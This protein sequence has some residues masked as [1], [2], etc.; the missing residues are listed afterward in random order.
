[1][2]E[3]HGESDQ[4]AGLRRLFGRPE[5][6]IVSFAA[7]GPGVGKS[8]LVANLA[9][10][11]ARAGKEVLV[12]DE[13]A[14]NSVAAYYGAHTRHDLQQ[15]VNREKT[16]AEVMLTVA[17]GIRV[18]PAARAVARLAKL[19]QRQQQAL[20]ETLTTLAPA[21]DIILVDASLDH[22][23]AFSPL[24][25]AADETVIVVSPSGAVMTEAYA[26]IKKVSLAYERRHFRILVSKV[27]ALQEG[28]A[29][30]RNFAEL[31]KSRGI[32]LLDFAGCV[33]NDP[34]V[35]QSRRLSQPVIGL[36]PDTPAA[37]AYRAIARELPNWK[38]A[39]AQASA[40]GV[41]KFVEQLLH[42]TQFPQADPVALYA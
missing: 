15:V 31:T 8:T 35:A 22:P 4:A 14:K 7:A 25:L 11:L 37:K 42:F 20:V 12:L 6:R 24:A 3:Y 41:E 27:S 23:L 21:A 30:Y 18:L 33:P 40:G 19:T 28:R 34:Q 36:F 39:A 2:A 17:P 13:N 38:S 9:A 10:A 26:L 32:A 5:P 1:M 29:V 16:L